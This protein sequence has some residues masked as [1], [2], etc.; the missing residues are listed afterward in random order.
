MKITKEYLR[1]LI[2]E[3]LEMETGNT[4]GPITVTPYKHGRPGTGT[5]S[6]EVIG[7]PVISREYERVV[8]N[9]EESISLYKLEPVKGAKGLSRIQ[10]PT[11]FDGIMIK[12]VKDYY[13]SNKPE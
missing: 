10:S 4:G 9:G 12:A 8:R 2:K 3:E 1:R 7:K 5:V 13:K 6:Y 11:E